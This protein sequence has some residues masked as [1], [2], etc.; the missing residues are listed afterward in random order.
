MFCKISKKSTNVCISHSDPN[1]KE[2]D[3]KPDNKSFPY[4]L[5]SFGPPLMSGIWSAKDWVIHCPSGSWPSASCD[6][7]ASCV[8]SG[9]RQN[10]GWSSLLRI[11]WHSWWEDKSLPTWNMS[12]LLTHFTFQLCVRWN[13][14][15]IHTRQPVTQINQVTQDIGHWVTPMCRIWHYFVGKKINQQYNSIIS[16]TGIH[17]NNLQGF[18]KMSR[19]EF[20]LQEQTVSTLC[21]CVTSVFYRWECTVTVGLARGRLS[22]RSFL[23]I[24]STVGI[25]ITRI[26][27]L[28][29]NCHP[30]GILCWC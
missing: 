19:V 24:C 13:V 30:L 18:N 26:V 7:A 2:N 11:I 23:C 20:R 17:F 21:V 5:P 16:T 8:S 6:V 10:T 14:I 3:S 12:M 1:K 4:T 15:Y 25:F 22:F 28:L 9:D 27:L 29:L